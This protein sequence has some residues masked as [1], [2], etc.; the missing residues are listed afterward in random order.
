MP[1]SHLRS[2]CPADSRLLAALGV[3]ADWP[4]VRCRVFPCQTAAEVRAALPPRTDVVAF[5][6]RNPVHRAHYELF[7][8]SLAA[9]NVSPDTVCL[10]SN[11]YPHTFSSLRPIAACCA[12]FGFVDGADALARRNSCIMV[13]KTQL[14]LVQA[15]RRP[16]EG[17]HLCSRH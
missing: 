2:P 6:C 8:R 14:H 10:V 12:W 3:P 5:Q 7:T 4:A 11:R 1:L 15:Q 17:M 9:P 16:P 13:I